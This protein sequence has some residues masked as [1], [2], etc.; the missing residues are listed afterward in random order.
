LLLQPLVENAVK[1]GALAEGGAGEVV[2]RARVD[3]V[4]R[5]LTCEVEDDGPG[6]ID[7]PRR[8]A[9]SLGDATREGGQGLS[10][11]RRRLAVRY[12]A[13]A[14]F[15]LEKCEGRT[16]AVVSLPAGP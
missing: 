4:T 7:E 8:V 2:V 15:R 1:H 10:I 3:K 9:S 13:L 12:G 16:R 14:S 6:P 11:V 5:T